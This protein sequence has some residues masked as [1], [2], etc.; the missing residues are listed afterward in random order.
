M[1]G[2][3]MTEKATAFGPDTVPKFRSRAERMALRDR[4][5][6]THRVARQSRAESRRIVARCIEERLI[7]ENSRQRTS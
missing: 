5:S 2:S 6:E 7:S 3:G 1:T 4:I